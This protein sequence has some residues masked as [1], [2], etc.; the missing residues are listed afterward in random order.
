MSRTK[1]NR[2]KFKAPKQ[3]PMSRKSIL[4]KCLSID[5]DT[6]EGQSIANYIRANIDDVSEAYELEDEP[7]L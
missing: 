2:T 5:D 3:K 4:Q 7:N 1:I 6:E